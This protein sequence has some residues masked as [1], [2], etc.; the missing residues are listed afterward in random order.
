MLSVTKVH[1][2]WT[3]LRLMLQKS[4]LCN[5]V[6]KLLLLDA[7]RICFCVESIRIFYSFFSNESEELQ[8]DRILYLNNDIKYTR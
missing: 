7:A 4:T 8:R 1:P 2:L 5:S 3:N 6:Y